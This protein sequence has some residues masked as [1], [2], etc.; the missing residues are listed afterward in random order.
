MKHYTLQSGM[1]KEIDW[2]KVILVVFCISIALLVASVAWFYLV[3]SPEMDRKAE[4]V[5]KANMSIYEALE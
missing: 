3:F 2:A 4:E 5:R 1:K